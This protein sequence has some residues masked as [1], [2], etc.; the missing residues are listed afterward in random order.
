M[1]LAITRTH[2]TDSHCFL[3]VRALNGG[4]KFIYTYA[5]GAYN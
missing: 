4:I 2:K 5:I 1:Q 3:A